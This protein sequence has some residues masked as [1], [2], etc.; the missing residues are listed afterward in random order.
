MK[1]KIRFFFSFFCDYIKLKDYKVVFIKVLLITKGECDFFFPVFF[2]S[3]S[4]NLWVLRVIELTL[5]NLR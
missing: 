2:S 3:G 5:F 1:K 4:A